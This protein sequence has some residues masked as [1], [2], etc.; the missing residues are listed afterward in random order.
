VKQSH[1]FGRPRCRDILDVEAR[2][3]LGQWNLV[4]HRVCLLLETLSALSNSP[5]SK[6]YLSENDHRLN[7]VAGW[8]FSRTRMGDESLP[9]CLSPDVPDSLFSHAGVF[10]VARGLQHGIFSRAYCV[11]V[12]PR[13][14]V[15]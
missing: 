9:H 1:T 3:L 14:Q 2:M 6:C 7:S 4:A 12:V 10:A 11:C 8:N 5:S 13:Y 15:P